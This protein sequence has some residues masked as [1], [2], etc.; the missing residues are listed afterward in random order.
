[1]A[2]ASANAAAWWLKTV[3]GVAMRVMV[4]S[5]RGLRRVSMDGL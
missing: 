1:V 3:R 4:G 2:S 5:F